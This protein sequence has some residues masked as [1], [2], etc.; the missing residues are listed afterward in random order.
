MGVLETGTI[1]MIIF[2]VVFIILTG[3]LLAKS[4]SEA[5]KRLAKE[6]EELKNQGGNSLDE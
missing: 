1:V 3:F 5:T 6:A 4:V 2:C